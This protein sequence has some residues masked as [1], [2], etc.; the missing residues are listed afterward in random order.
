MTLERQDHFDC[1][2]LGAKDHRKISFFA[3]LKQL[4]IRDALK[5]CVPHFVSFRRF[6]CELRPSLSLHSAFERLNR[7]VNQTAYLF[8]FFPSLQVDV[9]C[10]SEL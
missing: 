6:R 9:N 4:L 8:F 2:V 1:R 10:V 7:N 5:S 3:R